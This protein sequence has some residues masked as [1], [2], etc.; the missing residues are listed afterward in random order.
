MFRTDDSNICAI[1]VGFTHFRNCFFFNLTEPRFSALVVTRC[2][3][4]LEFLGIITCTPTTF[5]KTF[6]ESPT[7]E[8]TNMLCN[9]QY[10]HSK[11]EMRQRIDFCTRCCFLGFAFFL[12]HQK[13][14]WHLKTS[15]WPVVFFNAWA[16]FRTSVS[17]SFGL[18]WFYC[19][20][21]VLNA[22]LSN[23]DWKPQANQNKYPAPHCNTIWKKWCGPGYHARANSQVPWNDGHGEKTG[24]S[25]W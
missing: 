11:N 22:N 6:A 21:H 13:K 12:L 4:C 25:C 8:I 1:A 20:R 19:Y 3:S 7:K 17:F 24:A 15:A 9:W 23:T 18:P 5:T 10:W 2:V 16:R 14:F